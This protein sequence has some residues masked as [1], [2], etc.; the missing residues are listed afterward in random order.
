MLITTPGVIGTPLRIAGFLFELVS[1]LA[2]VRK[3]PCL[4]QLQ[5]EP[6]VRHSSSRGV[7]F[8][9]YGLPFQGLLRDLAHNLA[10]KFVKNG[11]FGSCNLLVSV[12]GC[13]PYTT[14]GRRE[15]SL[16]AASVGLKRTR[17]MV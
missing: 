7:H 12:L 15:S 5:E 11:P 6:V 14:A 8:C 10:V 13:E 16:H 4:F 9:F 3:E 17:G 1:A 2:I